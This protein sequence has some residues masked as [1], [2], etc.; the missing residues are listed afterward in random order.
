MWLANARARFMLN[1]VELATS[2]TVAVITVWCVLGRISWQYLCAC[3]CVCVHGPGEMM[4]SFI[5]QFPKQQHTFSGI[6]L[7]L[8]LCPFDDR[9]LRSNVSVRTDRFKRRRRRSGCKK[10]CD[11]L[12]RVTILKRPEWAPMPTFG[13]SRTPFAVRCGGGQGGLWENQVNWLS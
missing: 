13:E 12:A 6:F 11:L 8:S 5:F 4:E 2:S 3:V 1:S 9:F 10:R 7:F